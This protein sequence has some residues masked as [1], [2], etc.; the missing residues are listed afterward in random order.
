MT[1]HR[2]RSV[3]GAV[4]VAT[5]VASQAGAQQVRTV[6]AVATRTLATYT[7]DAVAA[8]GPFPVRVTIAD[9]SGTMIAH[10]F[11]RGSQVPTPMTVTVLESNLVLQG[12]TAEG[13]L[14]L[15]LDRAAEGNLSQRSTGRWALGKQEGTLVG[16]AR[17]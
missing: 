14:T 11:A 7:F 16:R 10:A 4:A 15:V 12:N 13:V 3:I 8:S 9:S 2:I 6:S 5:L 1:N 17:R